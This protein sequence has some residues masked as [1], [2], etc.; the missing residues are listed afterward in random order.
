MMPGGGVPMGV[1]DG[2]V[3]S[4]GLSLIDDRN[5]F[6]D[7]MVTTCQ[8]HHLNHLANTLA[9]TWRLLGDHTTTSARA[10]RA[11]LFFYIGLTYIG[12]GNPDLADRG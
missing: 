4:C 3:V 1:C 7:H 11:K 10:L 6:G 12:I 8:S 5:V 2:C 9:T